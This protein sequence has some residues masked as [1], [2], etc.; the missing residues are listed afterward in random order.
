MAPIVGIVV[1]VIT[2]LSLATP[3]H[4][5]MIDDAGITFAYS[6]NLAEGHGLVLQPGN[7]PEEAYSNTLWMLLLAGAGAVGISIPLA[8]KVLCTIIGVGVVVL[9][10]GLARF[11]FGKNES[12]E[13]YLMVGA[14]ALGAPFIIWS[15]SGLEHALQAFLFVLIV[16]GVAAF[17]AHRWITTACLSALVLM[18]PE[19]PL[20][21]AGVAVAYLIH[22]RGRG[23]KG[24]ILYLWPIAAFPFAVFVSL[25][26][27][28]LQYFGDPLPNPYYAKASEAS[29]LALL[30]VFGGGWDYTLSWLTATGA[31]LAVPV[32]AA[33]AW[34]K[35]PFYIL[36]CIGLLGAQ[37]G[38]VI[39]AGG[40]W[41]MTWRFMSPVVPLLAVLVAYALATSANGPDDSRMRVTGIAITGVLALLTVKTVV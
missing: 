21:C 27:F 40:D 36:V 18:R 22:E 11:A 16:T 1:V 13:G 38:F 5:W 29:F 12:F 37:L 20:I 32:L 6:D 30:N 35:V 19:T 23:I 14:F 17:D 10:V 31:V 7:E 33:A 25:I 39:F 8:A 28:R 9:V 4:D 26:V 41:M 3:L 24:L 2:Y 15:V 34:R